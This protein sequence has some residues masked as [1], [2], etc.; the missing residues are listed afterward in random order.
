V[1]HTVSMLGITLQASKSALRP[2]DHSLSERRAR[3]QEGQPYVWSGTS[4][5]SRPDVPDTSGCMRLVLNPDEGSP[6]WAAFQFLAEHHLPILLNRDELQL[7]PIN[8]SEHV[9]C[10]GS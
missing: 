7:S 3:D 5:R 2:V 9:P 6:L 4:G 10:C 1:G 8:V